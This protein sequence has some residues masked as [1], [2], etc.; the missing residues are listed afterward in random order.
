MKKTAIKS[1][2]SVAALTLTAGI[3]MSA[4]AG[5]VSE[6][7]VHGHAVPAEAVTFK[8]SEL[9]T[10]EGREAVE[11]RVRKAAEN[12]CGPSDYRIVGSLSRSAK[13]KEC[14]SQAVA[15]AMT[16]ITNDSVASIN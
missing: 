6:T 15:Q 2:L 5:S 14:Q 13:N 7:I 3:S 9:A 12:V 8:Q 10:A 11:Q 1:I 4:S 16:Q